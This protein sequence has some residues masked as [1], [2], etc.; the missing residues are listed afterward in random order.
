MGN[1]W[2]K[3]FG[4]VWLFLTTAA[5]QVP[6]LAR[7]T[8]FHVK[9][10]NPISTQSNKAGDQITASVL[11][12]PEFANDIISGTIKQSKSGGKIKGESVLTLGFSSIAHGGTVIPIRADVKSVVNSQGARDVD[13]EGQVVRKSNNLAKIAAGTG[14]GALVGALAGG[15]KGAAI[16]AGAGAAAAVIFVEVA[17]RG[18]NV[19]FAAGS[20]F[21]LSVEPR[22]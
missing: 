6:N 22:R 21:V 5:A 15:G 11:S 4:S 10:L 19:S 20:E 14:V 13:E 3:A 2:I 1:K 18:P 12:P 17:V 9:L 7:N 8:E 16:G